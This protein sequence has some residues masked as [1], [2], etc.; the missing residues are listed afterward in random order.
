MPLK[1]QQQQ[2]LQQMQQ[3]HSKSNNNNSNSGTRERTQTIGETDIDQSVL[4]GLHLGADGN[5]HGHKR[6]LGHRWATEQ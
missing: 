2:Q 1:Q 3:P 5:Y 4:N 6:Q